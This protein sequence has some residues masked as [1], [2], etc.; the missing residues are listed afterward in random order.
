MA[1]TRTLF[2][3][4]IDMWTPT[5]E[6]TA[7]PANAVLTLPSLATGRASDRGKPAPAH[8]LLV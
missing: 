1:V 2:A 8:G 6:S 7:P 3:Y 4:R 5:G